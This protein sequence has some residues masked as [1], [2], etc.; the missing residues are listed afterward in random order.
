MVELFTLPQLVGARDDRVHERAAKVFRLLTDRIVTLDPE[1]AELAKLFTNNW[2]YLKFAVAN[3]FYMIANGNGLD[4]ERIVRRWPT[5]TRVHPI[6]PGPDS[7][8]GRAC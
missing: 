3:Q 6:C 1:E 7:P 4:F 8:L 2:R 5:A